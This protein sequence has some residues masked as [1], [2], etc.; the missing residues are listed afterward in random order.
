MRI[1]DWSSDVCSSDLRRGKT[2]EAIKQLCGRCLQLIV[3]SHDEYFLR[4]V[5]KRCAGTS[6]VT[7][8]ID[9][10]DGDQWS[11]AKHVRLSDLCASDHTRRIEK[12]A[13]YSDHRAGDPDDIVLHVRQVLETH[14]RQIG[15]GS[16]R[17][18]VGQ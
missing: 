2:V 18:R 13:S 7:Y 14:I 1:S 6:T 12:L 11:D 15:S 4:D 17:E 10:S 3:L 5:G 9:Y 16:C 8:Q